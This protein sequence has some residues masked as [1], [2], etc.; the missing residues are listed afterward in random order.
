MTRSGLKCCIFFYSQ[1]SEP[2]K[3][4]PLERADYLE[5]FGQRPWRQGCQGTL[6]CIFFGGNNFWLISQDRNFPLKI[7][8]FISNI[9]L[10]FSE[11]KDYSFII[12]LLA[13]L[14][15]DFLDFSLFTWH[16]GMCL[17]GN[18]KAYKFWK[19]LDF[20]GTEYISNSN[21]KLVET[22]GF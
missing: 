19:H 11:G 4:D 22:A 3:P 2:V 12:H 10:K 8:R 7:R 14:L 16:L 18:S 5:Y 13:F 9:I 17:I 20:A 1:Y 15:C 21:T 6:F